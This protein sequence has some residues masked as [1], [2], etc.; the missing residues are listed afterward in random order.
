MFETKNCWKHPSWRREYNDVECFHGV[1]RQTHHCERY[2]GSTKVWIYSCRPWPLLHV[3]FFFR[4]M[5]TL[6]KHVDV[7]RLTACILHAWIEEL[8]DE[9]TIL[10]WLAYS[11]DIKKSRIKW[12]HFDYNVCFMDPQPRNLAQLANSLESAWL[13]GSMNTF[14]NLIY[15]IHVRFAVVHSRKGFWQVVKLM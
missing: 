15:S 5:A 4:M 7:R 12:D 8:Q 14:K 3:I 6:P 10:P 13:N 2:K 9:F 11:P 1:L